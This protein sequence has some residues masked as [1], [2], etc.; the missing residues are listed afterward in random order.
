MATPEEMQQIEKMLDQKLEPINKKLD[1]L[2]KVLSRLTQG[3]IS[4]VTGVDALN[5]E[6]LQKKTSQN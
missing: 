3:A 1:A 5:D 4:A 2:Q 6:K